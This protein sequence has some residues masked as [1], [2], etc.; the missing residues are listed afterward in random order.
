MSMYAEFDESLVTGN[1]EID[2]QHKEWIDK[3]NKLIKCCEEGGGKLEAIKTLEYMADY[4]EVHFAAEEKLQ[5][6]AAYPGLAE[7]KTK[8]EA[9]KVAVQ[10][11]HDML[12][13]EEGPS[14][15]FVKAVH[16]NVV[17]WVYNHIKAFDCSVAS[18]IHMHVNPERL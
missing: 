2:E 18:Y 6:E 1:K 14:E 5:E 8:H 10:E 9:F 7:H 15:A 17:N 13:E 4:A 3:I 12:E 11:L 16:D